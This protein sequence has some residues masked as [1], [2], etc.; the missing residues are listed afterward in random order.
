MTT[1]ELT[2]PANLWMS[3]NRPIANH[4]YKARIVRDIRRGGEQ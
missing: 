3:A 2:I 4:G 1:L